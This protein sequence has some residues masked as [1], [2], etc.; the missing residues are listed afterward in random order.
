M[1][2]SFLN[3]F[4]ELRDAYHEPVP[5]AECAEPPASVAHLDPI[6]VTK[7]HLP[8][9]QE[10]IPELEGIWER[11]VLTNNGPLHQ[12]L[13][14][15]LAR[16]LG[17][18]YVSLFSSGT[19]ALMAALQYLNVQG[20]VI[21][22]PYSF[23]ATSHALL[24]NRL[25]PVF[26]DI[27]PDTLNLDPVK[28][29]AAITPDTT[30]ILPVH[31]YGNPCDVAAIQE[32]ADRHDLKVIYDAA[33]AFGVDDERG[34]ILG[35]GDLATLSF[36]ATKVFNTFEGGAIVCRDAATKKCI[37]R[38]KNFGFV[39]ETT[40][41]AAGINGKLSEFNSAVGLHA[42]KSIDEAIAQRGEVDRRYR[43][44]LAGV[45]GIRCVPRA[46]QLRDNYA[47]FP[48]LV[49]PEFPLSRNELY[50][51]FV[52]RRI[53]PRKYFYPLISSHQMYSRFPS[54]DETE[55]PIAKAVSEGVLCLPIYPD[56]SAENQRRVID[57]ILDAR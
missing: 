47:Y 49:D 57:T 30:A 27:D 1:D 35:H 56:L 33:H 11:A 38:V 53:F 52:K 46:G 45:R 32:V 12:R 8:P 10:L 29:G 20:E 51:A 3:S 21:T 4:T 19:T 6:Y 43:R 9:L 36:H 13:E 18:P 42:L 15:K 55:L 39:D 31:C 25:K 5:L 41:V 16:S 24:W 26:V 44:A 17:V 54:A 23:I 2:N 50:D 40:V 22:T 28:L 37:D 14:R 34:S 7:P 48:I